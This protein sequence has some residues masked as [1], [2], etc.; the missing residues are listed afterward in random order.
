MRGAPSREL[1]PNLAI[2]PGLELEEPGVLTV[3]RQELLVTAALDDFAL[4][5]DHD[6]LGSANR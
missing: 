5:H 3:Q 2:A 6:Q 1:Y 4:V